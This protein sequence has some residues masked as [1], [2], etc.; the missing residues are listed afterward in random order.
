MSTAED[1][2]DVVSNK[3][4]TYYELH[5]EGRKKY[6]R[7]HYARNKAMIT[8]KREV[9][10]ALDEQG[11][12]DYDRYQEEYYAKNRERILK[13]RRDKYAAARKAT[14][15]AYKPRIKQTQ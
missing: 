14:G 7:E 13:R 5:R 1:S 8:R 2:Q 11:K 6:Q 3:G 12:S 4:K 10:R 15:K 9:A